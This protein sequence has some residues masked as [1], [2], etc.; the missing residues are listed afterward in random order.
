MQPLLFQLV[1]FVGQLFVD[2]P[3]MVDHEIQDGL[4]VIGPGLGQ[5]VQ[6]QGGVRYATDSGGRNSE[7]FNYC[8]TP[9]AAPKRR[10]GTIKGT[11]P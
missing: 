1:E 7:D 6:Y 10:F 9:C 5:E 11:T 8:G 3:R 4:Y 2:G